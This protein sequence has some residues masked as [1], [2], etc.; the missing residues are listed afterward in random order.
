MRLIFLHALFVINCFFVVNA[1]ELTDST[2]LQKMAHDLHKHPRKTY[3][4]LLMQA[5]QLDDM[6]PNYKLWWLLRKAEAENLLYFFDKSEK[7]I[8]ASVCFDH[9]RYPSTNNH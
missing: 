4:L 7:T 5:K 1:V 8:E 2:S 6:S 3:D 9:A